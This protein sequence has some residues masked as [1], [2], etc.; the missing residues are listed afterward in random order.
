MAGALPWRSGQA[1]GGLS[2]GERRHQ[3]AH[4][5]AEHQASPAPRHPPG[6]QGETDAQ[7]HPSG[8]CPA[9]RYQLL[10]TRHFAFY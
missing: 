7:K 5:H 2:E 3:A 10:N 8:S 9:S 6:P 4:R 1:G